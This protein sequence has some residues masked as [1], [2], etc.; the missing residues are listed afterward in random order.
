MAYVTPG[1]VAA[2]DVATAAAWN[3]LTNDVIAHQASLVNIKQTALTSAFGTA[4]A[5]A[6]TTGDIAGL[7]VAITPSANTS[8]IL[9][10]AFLSLDIDLSN[11]VYALLHRDGVAI[12]VGDASGSRA[13][14][15]SGF[16]PSANMPGLLSLSFLDSPATTSSVTYSVRLRTSSGGT[17]TIYVNRGPGD[18]DNGSTSRAI[19]T[20]TVQEVPV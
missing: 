19:S 5:T 2:G 17:R 9:V 10:S 13:R 1:T 6:T 7:T 15:T 3:V 12:G 18:A 16:L 14:V 20:I 11:L 8:K 4:V